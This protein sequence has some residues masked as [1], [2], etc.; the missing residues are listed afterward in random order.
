MNRIIKLFTISLLLVLAAGT[1][2]AQVVG[3]KTNALY[4]AAGGTL[5]LGLEVAVGKKTT[6]DFVAT[7]NPWIFGPRAENRKIWHWS[8]NGEVRFW[9]WQKFTRGFIGLH[10]LGG[11]FDSGGITLP[12]GTFP[13]IR[14]NRIEGGAVGIGLSYG[15][16][17]Y[18][19]PH[20]SLEATLGVGYMYVVYDKFTCRTCFEKIED[21]T[22]RH[23]FGPT[24]LGVSFMYLFGSKKR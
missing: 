3:I 10:L 21:N 6:L 7:G 15:W 1:A 2:K 8:A 9:H 24:K 23:Y 11:A 4:W 5:N 18:L 20:W 22:V 19:S 14:D 17:W 13:G 12:L 16:Q